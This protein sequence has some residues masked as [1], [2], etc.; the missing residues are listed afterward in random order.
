MSDARVHAPPA[1]YALPEPD[2]VCRATVQQ[3]LVVR[4]IDEVVAKVSVDRNG[5]LELVE[6]LAPDVTPAEAQELRSAYEACVW[7]PGVGPGGENVD[8]SAVLVMRRR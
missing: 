3:K 5:K 8:G 1:T 2:P 4:G 6:L 7:I